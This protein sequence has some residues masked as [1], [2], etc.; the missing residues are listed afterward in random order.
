MGCTEA[1]NQ[2]TRTK[3]SLYLGSFCHSKYGPCGV[4]HITR[5]ML[6]ARL[7]E[8][9]QA[10]L[11]T[12]S[13]NLLVMTGGGGWGVISVLEVRNTTTQQRSTWD[14]GT[15]HSSACFKGKSLS[16]M[17]LDLVGITMTTVMMPMA[18]IVTLALYL[19]P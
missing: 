11:K 16:T 19:K 2:V 9:Q 10:T 18:L 13:I 1:L 8:L 17:C 12:T 7:Y 5:S 14:L 3:L 15:S 6:R 4:P